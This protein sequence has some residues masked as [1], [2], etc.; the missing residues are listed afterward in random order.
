MPLVK[1]PQCRR[2]FHVTVERNV[3]PNGKVFY[4]VIADKEDV[5]HTEITEVPK[6]D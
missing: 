5:T 3:L 2:I 6:R 1:C 4:R